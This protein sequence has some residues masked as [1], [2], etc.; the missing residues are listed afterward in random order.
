[1]E[2]DGI[3]VFD[4]ERRDS[5]NERRNDDTENEEEK[6]MRMKSMTLK[7]VTWSLQP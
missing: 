7:A 1:M 5:E 6:M 3:S 4:E 2:F